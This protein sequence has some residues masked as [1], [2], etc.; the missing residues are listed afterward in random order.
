MAPEAP[1]ILG[2]GAHGAR[3]EGGPA[4]CHDATVR[5]PSR[6]SSAR[7]G[8]MRSLLVGLALLVAAPALA[9]QSVPTIPFE[10]VPDPLKLPRDLYFGEV[11]GVAVN[12]MGS[13]FT[14]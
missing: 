1:V 6:T 7:G 5:L 3:D 11:S 2:G 13:V 8:N 9:Q 10:S 12:S 14:L 4:P